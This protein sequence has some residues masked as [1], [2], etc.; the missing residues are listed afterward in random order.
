MNGF[1]ELAAARDKALA[2]QAKALPAA[3]E[4]TSEVA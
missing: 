2:T 3:E 1:R 4:K